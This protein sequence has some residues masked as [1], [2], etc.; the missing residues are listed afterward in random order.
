MV[1][2]LC[3]SPAPGD[4]P[5]DVWRALV[6]QAQQGEQQVVS[7]P[8]NIISSPPCL[9]SHVLISGCSLGTWL[10]LEVGVGMF[11]PSLSC[12]SCPGL[13]GHS[14]S[15]HTTKLR[16]WGMF[17]TTFPSRLFPKLH[18]SLHMMQMLGL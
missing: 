18:P 13:F 2:Q 10:C 11:S 1:A 8:E 12:L 16:P 9:L 5:R 4:K 3:S 17:G 6:I 14:A 15:T 7:R